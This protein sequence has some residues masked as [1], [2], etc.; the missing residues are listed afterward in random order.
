[1]PAARVGRAPGADRH[2]LCP[3]PSR[4]ECRG[5]AFRQMNGFYCLTNARENASQREFGRRADTCQLWF[6]CGEKQ[7]A[8]R[9]R[10]TCAAL[11]RAFVLG[12]MRGNRRSSEYSG[13]PHHA[14][15]CRLA[16]K[17]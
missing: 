11:L 16:G 9:R 5:F 7:P 13:P 14:G 3:S 6:I 4:G 15:P 1:M 17:F 2:R 8:L 12:R 10:M